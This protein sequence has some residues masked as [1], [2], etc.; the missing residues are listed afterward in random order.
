M[1][2]SISLIAAIYNT[3]DFRRLFRSR[4][5]AD[6]VKSKLGQFYGLWVSNTPQYF[7][8]ALIL[9]LIKYV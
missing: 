3:K 4:Y 1:R 6:L 5:Q 2:P 9:Y 8:F 7:Y